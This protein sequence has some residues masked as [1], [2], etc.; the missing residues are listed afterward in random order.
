MISKL[1]P[2][3]KYLDDMDNSDDEKSVEY[4]EEESVEDDLRIEEIQEDENGLYEV[5]A[6]VSRPALGDIEVKF[7]GSHN[8]VIKTEA[9][10]QAEL[11]S[12]GFSRFAQLLDRRSSSQR[13]DAL[14]EDICHDDYCMVCNDAGNLVCCETCPC[15]VH[16]K[17]INVSEVHYSGSR[18]WRCAICR[19]QAPTASLPKIHEDNFED[20][21]SDCEENP[22]V[23]G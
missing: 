1:Q 13:N 18:V 16:A 11:N 14:E 17:C 6:F 5:E 15:V 3:S 9:E 7:V 20:L 19:R 12:E 8:R 10:L 4:G 23:R 21:H 2:W 22:A